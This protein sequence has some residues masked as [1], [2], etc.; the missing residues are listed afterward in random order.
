MPQGLFWGGMALAPVAVLILLFGQSTG[1][2]RVAVVLAV[3]TIVMLAVSMAIRPSVDMVRVDI[4][5]RVLDE[6]ERIRLR[7]QSETAHVARHTAAALTERIHMLNATIEDLRAQVDEA[8]AMSYFDPNGPAAIGP[9]PAGA[10]PGG[11]RIETVHVTRRTM[12]DD[13]GTVYGSRSAY[14]RGGRAVEGEWSEGSDDRDE[15]WDDRP[16]SEAR[17]GTRALPPSRGEAAGRYVDDRDDRYGADRHRDDRH[18]DRARYDDRARFDDRERGYDRSEEDRHGPRRGY[19]R[20]DREPD[21]YD[22]ERAYDRERGYDRDRGHERDRGY[23]RER[24]YDRPDERE[25]G[26]GGYDRGPD[27]GR[28]DDRDH[29]RPRSPEW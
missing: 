17:P 11:R 26:Y 4:E 2:L 3:L 6:M 16:W 29:P 18:D 14:G 7:T 23:E 27:R 24:G 10:P 8:Q 22:R 28:Y 13:T 5:H 21:R 15:R 25:R 9:G 19:D 1:A 20:P 12:Y